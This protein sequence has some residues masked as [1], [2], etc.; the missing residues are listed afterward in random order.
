M[1]SR[2]KL[3]HIQELLTIIVPTNWAVPTPF[4]FVNSVHSYSI[5]TYGLSLHMASYTSYIRP[6][7]V[8]P[9][10][11]ASLLCL[12]S[13]RWKFFRILRN[14]GLTWKENRRFPKMSPGKLTCSTYSYLK[15]K[16]QSECEGTWLGEGGKF[17]FLILCN[18]LTVPI[19]K[20][21]MYTE[22]QTSIFR[23]VL[24]WCEPCKNP[25]KGISTKT[26]RNHLGKIPEFSAASFCQRFLGRS[27]PKGA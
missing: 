1:R 13:Q 20:F 18:L 5:I 21:Q 6:T 2:L 16:C 22:N 12:Y 10:W 3:H 14:I 15:W 25:P 8:L 19:S 17:I 11:V 9:C 24:M 7:R 27:M 26:F 4:L 23:I